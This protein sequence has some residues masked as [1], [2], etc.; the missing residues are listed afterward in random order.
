MTSVKAN[1]IQIESDTFG[2]PSS[3]AL[4][5]IMGLGGQLIYW[6]DEFCQQ[7]A[8]SGYHV[9]RYDNRDTGLSTKFEGLST[10][11]IME[12]IGALFMGQEVSVPYTIEDMAGDAVGLLDVLNIDK[13][14]I[15]GMSMGGFIA[16]TFALKNP[17]RTLSLTSIYSTPGNRSQYPPTQEVKE[18]MM[19]PIPSERGPYIDY[20]LKFFKLTFGSGLSFDE[21]FYKT[22]SEKAYDRSLCSEGTGRQY[23]AIMS[24][25][26]RTSELG[27]LNVPSLIIHGDADPLV[28]LAGGQATADAIPGAEL[29]IVKGMGHVIPNLNAYW[30][31]I[32]DAIIEHVGKAA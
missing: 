18:A 6:Q 7:I 29:M 19:E 30:S 23:L 2:D 15:C 26:D 8:D 5:L 24:Q 28:P 31:D 3:P 17:S 22:L 21:D 10:E 27:E 13:A 12:K 1:G 14:H 4:L 11:E 32:K 20:M 25:K 9:I 16:Q